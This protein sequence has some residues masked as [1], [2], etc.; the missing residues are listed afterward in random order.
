MAINEV[1]AAAKVYKG[2]VRIGYELGA[3]VVED[4]HG[5]ISRPS[6]NTMAWE[7][8]RMLSIGLIDS[9]GARHEH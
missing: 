8:F 7:L 4:M 1:V 3:L 2:T 5:R 9:V 6:T